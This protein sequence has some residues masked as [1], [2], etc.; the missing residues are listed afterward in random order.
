MKIYKNVDPEKLKF[1]EELLEEFGHEYCLE[2]FI[3]A[4]KKITKRGFICHNLPS[5][6]I[7]KWFMSLRPHF[8]PHV[9]AMQEYGTDGTA[10]MMCSNGIYKY[11]QRKRILDTIIEAN[12]R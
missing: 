1:S 3:E 6:K 10:W 7:K 11:L 5:N 9:K 4:R 8:M 12:K 2:R